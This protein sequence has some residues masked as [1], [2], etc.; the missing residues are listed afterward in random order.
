MSQ[1]TVHPGRRACRLPLGERLLELL[2]GGEQ[3]EGD[4]HEGGAHLA[5]LPGA[6]ESK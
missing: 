4:V 3:L 6:G 1:G 5:Q 2:D